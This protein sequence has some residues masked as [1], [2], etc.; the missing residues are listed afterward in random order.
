MDRVGN[1]SAR[2]DEPWKGWNV[3]AR[4]F[5]PGPTLTPALRATPLSVT[6]GEGSRVSGG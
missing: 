2:R 6:L 1:I 3:V 5:S 4:A